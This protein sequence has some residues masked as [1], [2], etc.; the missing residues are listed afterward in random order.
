MNRVYLHDTVENSGIK[1]RIIQN[2][3]NENDREYVSIEFVK[4]LWEKYGSEIT[5]DFFLQKLKGE[6]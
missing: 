6:K 3:I 1:T 2:R 4:E 5:P